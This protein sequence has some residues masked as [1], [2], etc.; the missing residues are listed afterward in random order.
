MRFLYV[1][2]I[3]SIS[4]E[5]IVGEKIFATGEPLRIAPP[6]YSGAGV[7]GTTD[8]NWVVAPGAISE[9]IG[10]LA[11]WCV[12]HQTGFAGRPV[13]MFA[14][15]IEFFNDVRT[16]DKV[17]LRAQVERLDG[18]EMVF[19]GSAES[20]SGLVCR[21]TSCHC[22]MAPLDQMEIPDDTRSRFQNLI[23]EGELY[24][25]GSPFQLSPVILSK[26]VEPGLGKLT[27]TAK[28]LGDSFF[29]RD[30]FP[31]RPVT[32]IIMINEVIGE[33]TK[34]LCASEQSTGR[35]VPRVVEGLKIRNFIEPNEEFSV[36]VDI[37]SKNA[38]ADGLIRL[39]TIT[40]VK[41]SDKMILRGRYSY[42]WRMC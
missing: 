19:S 39:Q 34:S 5:I 23:G 11:S 26:R 35:L 40:Q 16:G 38:N 20:S 42:E 1:N 12:L 31:L 22:H 17:V 28:F 8:L 2:K 10:Q 24:G 41:K 32:P 9:A 4:P 33:M 18:D 15:R 13:F 25:N 36:N 29:Y 7:E 37:V 6:G 27:G 14:D 30:H 3:L 21:I